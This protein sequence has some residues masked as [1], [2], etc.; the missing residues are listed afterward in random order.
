MYLAGVSV[1]RIEDITEALWGS[2]VSPGT[3]S[4]LNK[5][6]YEQIEEWRIRPI[7]GTYPYV[8]VNGIYLKRSRGGEVQNVAVLVA[9]G[10]NADGHREIIGAAEGM[11]EDRESWRAFFIWLKE[12]GLKGVRLIV[13]DKCSG[14]WK[15]CRKFFLRQNISA[16]R[17]IFTGIFSRLFPKN[18]RKKSRACSRRS[19]LRNVKPP[20]VKKPDKY[21]KNSGK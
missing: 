11:K 2:K 13:G 12:R 21:V 8:Y 5:K 18:R 7:T 17:F 19:T 9:I 15:P 1:R 3:I 6:A 10:V 14:C 16:V 4:N 20:P